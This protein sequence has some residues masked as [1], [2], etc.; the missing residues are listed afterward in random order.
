MKRLC[1]SLVS[2]GRF[3]QR[4]LV[5]YVRWHVTKC[6][7]ENWDWRRGMVNCHC[8]NKTNCCQQTASDT[9]ASCTIACTVDFVLSAINH[10]TGHTPRQPNVTILECH[11]RLTPKPTDTKWRMTWQSRQ[12]HV[13]CQNLQKSSRR[14]PW[15]FP[16][17]FASTCAFQI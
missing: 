6:L 16:R 5:G 11:N 9:T 10:S 14:R 13:V 4:C 1:C 12:Y 17:S 15:P 7:D 8:N 2:Q 3:L